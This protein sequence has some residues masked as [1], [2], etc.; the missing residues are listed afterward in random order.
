MNSQ[1]IKYA[2]VA[3]LSVS[4]IGLELIWTRILSA[5]FYYTFSF[6][7]ISFA[8]LG[9]SMGS[10]SLRLFKG[11][12][13]IK[14]MS[15]YIGLS[16][17][18]SFVSPI[19]LFKLQLDFSILF[20][21]PF[22]MLKFLA[23][24]LLLSSSFYFGGLALALIFKTDH[25]DMPKIYMADMMGA[26]ISVIF[27]IIL[28][29]TIGTLNAT[30]IVS[31]FLILA[32]FISGGKKYM[33]ILVLVLWALSIGK[34]D[35]LLSSQR[36]ERAPVIYEH[37]DAMA[38]IKLYEYAPNYRGIN[39]DNVANS[40]VI[41]F[42]GNIDDPA[43][44]GWDIDVKNLID[45]FD[46]CTFLS[47]GA[48]G[49]ADVMQA[50]G[51]DAAEVHAVEVNPH[52]NKMMTRG[53]LKGYIIPDSI[54][55][56]DAF[57]ITTCN[58][59]SGNLYNHERVKVVSEDART[60]IRRFKN[61]FDIIYSL[62]SNTWAALGSGSFA[63]AENYIFT[64]EAFIDYWQA[65]SDT[66]F[67]S[68]EHQMYMPRIVSSAMDALE[69]MNV[70]DPEKHIAVYQIPGMRRHLML[71][72]K[73][74]LDENLIKNAYGKLDNGTYSAKAVLY[75]L[76]DP[77]SSNFYSNIIEHGWKSEYKNAAINISPATDD[78]P[79]IAQLG[80]W[81]N[82]NFKNLERVSILSDFRGFPLTKVLLL[83]ILIVILVIIIPI[84]LLPYIKSDTT[85]KTAP[86]FYFF[87]LGVAYISVEIIL[88]QKYTLYIGASFYSIATILF[89]MLLAS[90]IGSRFSKNFS[91][92]TVFLSIVL[93][94]IFNI[95]ASTFLVHHLYG[96][97]I[98]FRSLLAALMVFPL[99][100]F[101]GMPF[102][103]GTLKVGELIDWGFAVNGAASVLG[104]VLIML[105]V[106]AWGFTV[107]LLLS[108]GIYIG[109]FLL[110]EYG[111]RW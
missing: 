77:D 74:T 94:L 97:P 9:M 36:E 78:K 86:W 90:G 20:S 30:F 11:L 92:R 8:I 13:N 41:G 106:F 58:E 54:E 93:L 100:F 95:F 111:K 75:P 46:H 96:L 80:R 89:S 43:L 85:L 57:P 5:E 45:R 87:L 17:L 82:F 16:A 49:G 29:N 12:N 65:L 109:A 68:M 19:L 44:E 99:A 48:G 33:P 79:F 2:L 32:A 60:Y 40:P 1:R 34:A 35:T 69:K 51:Y 39:I 18:F 23:A 27:C 84:C 56:K 72:S 104:S 91:N 52:I 83:A 53:D 37:W 107:A 21:S 81:K 70:P 22:M 14:L 105:I 102:P 62:S 50:L 10:L 63:F 42:D 15:T 64:T 67:L 25:K 88:M 6:L 55:S 98:F 31:A 66:G 24:V 26:G 61:K 7:I 103:K 3:L 108:A 4:F 59:F 110:M 71:M 28:M 47:L 76:S 38:K 101:M 73:D